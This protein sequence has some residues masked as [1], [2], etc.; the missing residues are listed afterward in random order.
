MSKVCKN[1]STKDKGTS[2]PIVVEQAVIL[3]LGKQRQEHLNLK[4]SLC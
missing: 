3:A 1:D 4:V 2:V